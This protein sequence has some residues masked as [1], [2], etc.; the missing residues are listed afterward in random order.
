MSRYSKF[1][2]QRLNKLFGAKHKLINKQNL[3]PP[4][5]NQTPTSKKQQKIQ[6]T[7]ANPRKSKK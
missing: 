7:S 6:N 1:D 4:K 3:Q 5:I 2:K